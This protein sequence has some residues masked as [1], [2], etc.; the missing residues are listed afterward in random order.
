MSSCETL[1]K[2]ALP[3]AAPRGEGWNGE[4]GK[5]MCEKEMVTHKWNCIWK[6]KGSRFTDQKKENS[7]EEGTIKSGD[8]L[9]PE[10]IKVHFWKNQRAWI[11]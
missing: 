1:F 8:C 3:T 10:L 9:S 6:W 2:F 5:Y 4:A 11:E 7:C